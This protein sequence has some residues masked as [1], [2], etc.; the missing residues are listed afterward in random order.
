MLDG[1]LYLSA[2][3]LV[4]AIFVGEKL[5]GDL[6]GTQMMTV[7]QVLCSID[8]CVKLV[9]SA[10]LVV[11]SFCFTVSTLL[12]SSA[13]HVSIFLK[14]LISFLIISLSPFWLT[15]S[16]PYPLD[17]FDLFYLSNAIPSFIHTYLTNN[18]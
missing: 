10:Y 3:R 12:S 9:L 5:V 7:K 2:G 4:D 17:L 8:L 15:K 11:C 1:E 14:D 13:L 18:S 16:N 6:T